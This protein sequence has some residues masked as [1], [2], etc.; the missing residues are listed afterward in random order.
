MVL[1]STKRKCLFGSVVYETIPRV[2]YDMREKNPGQ[3]LSGRSLSAHTMFV[4]VFGQY[5]F[6]G[7]SLRGCKGTH[8]ESRRKG[9]NPSSLC[10]QES[11]LSIELQL[12]VEA[13]SELY[14]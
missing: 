10:G 13:G 5:V 8:A 9:E 6:L 11:T 1:N 12:H 3:A 2:V 7:V 4:C 14:G